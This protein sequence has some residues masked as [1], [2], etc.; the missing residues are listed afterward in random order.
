MITKLGYDKVSGTNP[1][2]KFHVKLAKILDKIIGII[3]K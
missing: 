3:Q 1:H 2:T